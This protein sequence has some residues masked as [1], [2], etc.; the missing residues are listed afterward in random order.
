VILQPA[1]VGR[2]PGLGA[3]LAVVR[4]GLWQ[5]PWQLQQPVAEFY[6]RAMHPYHY[7]HCQLECQTGT[8]DTE[9]QIKGRKR[10]PRSEESNLFASSYILEHTCFARVQ[11]P[12]ILVN[13]LRAAGMQQSDSSSD[14]VHRPSRFV[15][16]SMQRSRDGK[17]FQNPNPPIQATLP[18]PLLA[19]LFL[20]GNLS[21]LWSSSKG[22]WPGWVGFV[23]I[24]WVP[25][26]EQGSKGVWERFACLL[27]G[28][29]IYENNA[30]LVVKPVCWSFCRIKW[31]DSGPWIC[32]HYRGF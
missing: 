7:R 29:A 1:V 24:H 21:K 6:R 20:R 10:N 12:S 22:N 26:R 25:L 32:M 2:W 9:Q 16:A 14:S 5:L 8:T 11:K 18:P 15:V 4:P 19:Q 17:S 23:D 31:T 13:R 30:K 27:R 3:A 28:N